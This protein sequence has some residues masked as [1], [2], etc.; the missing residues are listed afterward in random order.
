MSWEQLGAIAEEIRTRRAIED[1][2]PPVA[3]PLDGEP[4]EQTTRGLHCK[5]HGGLIDQDGELRP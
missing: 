5:F 1:A 4:L 2:T 3:C